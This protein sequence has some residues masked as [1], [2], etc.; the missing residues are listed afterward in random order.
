[1]IIMDLQNINSVQDL[2]KANHIDTE[3]QKL[4]EQCSF[5]VCEHGPQV[6]LGVVRDLLCTLIDYHE[7]VI[8]GQIEENDME[9][10]ISWTTDLQALRLSLSSLKDVE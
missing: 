8:E 4:I 5:D 6:S 2:L 9:A 3:N 7:M 10:I 1:M